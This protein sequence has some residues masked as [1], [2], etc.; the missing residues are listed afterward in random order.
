MSGDAAHKSRWMIAEVV[1]GVPFL[2]GIVL[3]FAFP[4]ALAPGALRWVLALAGSALVV[5]GVAE[6]VVRSRLG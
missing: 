1:F 6:N 5:A 4:L 3:Q 2:L